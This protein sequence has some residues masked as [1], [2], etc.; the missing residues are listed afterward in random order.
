L[1]FLIR[2]Q[3]RI[4]YLCITGLPST[5][6]TANSSSVRHFGAG[7]I[8]EVAPSCAKRPAKKQS[9]KSTPQRKTG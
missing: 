2:L 8:V 6:Q 9:R 5:E 1:I 7:M 3:R 4:V